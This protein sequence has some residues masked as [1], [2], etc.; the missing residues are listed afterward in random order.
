MDDRNLAD[1]ADPNQLPPTTFSSEAERFHYDESLF[2]RLNKQSN[3]H[4]QLLR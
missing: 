1:G 3:A 2:V 4:V